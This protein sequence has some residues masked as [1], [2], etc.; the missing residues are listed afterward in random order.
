MPELT[1]E[2]WKQA[3]IAY[4][5]DAKQVITKARKSSAYFGRNYCLEEA[6]FL[7][8]LANDCFE[9]YDYD[10]QKNIDHN[11]QKNIVD[12]LF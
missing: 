1:L 11:Q 9:E 8:D 10:R 2:E 7:L 3:G 6:T 4:I 5:A 12:S